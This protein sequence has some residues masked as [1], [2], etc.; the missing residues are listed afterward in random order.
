MRFWRFLSKNGKK[1]PSV[2]RPWGG[3]AS[4]R[5]DGCGLG[6][7]TCSSGWALANLKIL[8]S[9]DDPHSQGSLPRTPPHHK[10]TFVLL[11]ILKVG[12]S[13]R[14]V[15]C[16]RPHVYHQLSSVSPEGSIL[17][18]LGV[19]GGRLGVLGGFQRKSSKIAKIAKK[20]KKMACRLI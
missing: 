20:S 17:G 4:R 13:R 11:L 7:L 10:V 3:R 12:I 6:Y 15:M 18:I 5:V 19:L 9:R 14:D 8:G 2:G 16:G 1:S